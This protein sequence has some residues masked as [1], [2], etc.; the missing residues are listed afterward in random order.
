MQHRSHNWQIYLD[1]CCLSR[2]FDTQTQE[3][4]QQETQAI[5][6]II[7]FFATNTTDWKWIISD[8]LRVEIDKNPNSD[9][10]N[11]IKSLL[12]Y[13]HQN[14]YITEQEVLRAVH[15]KSL[16][17]KIEDALHLS[18]AEQGNVDVF[19][20]TD[21]KLIRKAKSVLDITQLLIRVEN[22]YTWLQEIFENEYP[23]SVK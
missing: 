17:F 14:I 18:C 22:P 15:L 21:D 5:A 8:F 12:N 10:R 1:T 2:F 16:G 11:A 20:T 9:Q 4:I 3:R 19:L 7:G 13:A 6:L 23:S